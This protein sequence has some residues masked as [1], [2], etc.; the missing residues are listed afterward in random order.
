[1]S[2]RWELFAHA[3]L[4]LTITHTNGKRARPSAKGGRY[5]PAVSNVVSPTVTR[6]CELAPDELSGPQW[7]SGVLAQ[8]VQCVELSI[9]VGNDDLLTVD[10]HRDQATGRGQDG[11]IADLVK[12]D[13]RPREN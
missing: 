4:H 8:A 10:D 3:Q 5:Q 9:D 1:M 11:R 7:S 13:A 12:L 6:T 2:A